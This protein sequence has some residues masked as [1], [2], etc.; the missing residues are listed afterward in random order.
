M[1]LLS[2]CVG[3]AQETSAKS[4]LTGHF[5]T[6]VPEVTITPEG[7]DGDT[8][9]D[10][11]HHGGIDQAVYLFGDA[12]LRWWSETLG[13]E[14]QPGFFGENLLISNLETAD[15]A[16]G[17][18]FNVGDVVLQLTSP[19]IPCATYAAHI[20]TPQAIKQ[21]Y[22][23]ARPGT[24]ARVLKRGK[25]QVGDRVTHHAFAGPRITLAENM[26]SFLRKHDDDDFLRR[27]LLVPAHHKLHELAKQR[28]GAA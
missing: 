26:A 15:L 21:F 13:K 11:K 18:I 1:K 2:I 20:D 27:A 22:A 23:A 5:K 17:D 28:L 19:R 3:T 10:R 16:L 12:D 7:L 14:L 24:Y 6:P 8:I 25:V 4:G 9:V